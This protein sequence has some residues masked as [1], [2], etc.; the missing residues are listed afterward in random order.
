MFD[1]SIRRR[2]RVPYSVALLRL[3]SAFVVMLFT[4]TSSGS[5]GGTR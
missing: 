5:F 4:G 2:S 1:L 3:F